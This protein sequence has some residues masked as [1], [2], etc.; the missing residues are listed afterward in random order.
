MVHEPRRFVENVSYITSPGWRVKQWP[1]GAMVPR[2][3]TAHLFVAD[4]QR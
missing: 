3:S 1:G 2:N 4:R